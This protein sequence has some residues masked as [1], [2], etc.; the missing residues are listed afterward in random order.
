MGNV[1]HLHPLMI[2][3]AVLGGLLLF[4]VV[5]LV[6]GPMVLA[7]MLS[8]LEVYRLHFVPNEIEP[9]DCAV[10]PPEPETE[11]ADPHQEN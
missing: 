1:T 7:L 5:G 9:K 11:P 10:P 8:L 4:G 3:F 2:F 6:L